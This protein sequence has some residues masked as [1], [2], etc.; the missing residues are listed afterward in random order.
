MDIWFV[1]N[2]R[3]SR[4]LRMKDHLSAKELTDTEMF[5]VKT[6][7]LAEFSHEIS[8]LK[9]GKE[10]TTNSK[11]LILRPFLDQ[12]GLLQVGGRLNLSNQ[13]FAIQNLDYLSWK[14]EIHDTSC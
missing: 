12:R 13:E 7:Q 14:R 9:A 2:T 1:T 4:E 3:V 6:T 11:I 10:L 8:T 5:C